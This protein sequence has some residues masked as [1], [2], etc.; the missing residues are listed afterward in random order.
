ME[1]F[2]N[3]NYELKEDVIKRIL[4]FWYLE[5][6][7]I[8]VIKLPKS[9]DVQYCIQTVWS[10]TKYLGG[11]NHECTKEFR[12]LLKWLSVLLNVLCKLCG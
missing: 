12:F 10:G 1:F 11:E 9:K 2:A 6:T 3:L 8:L 5:K 7:K 4:L